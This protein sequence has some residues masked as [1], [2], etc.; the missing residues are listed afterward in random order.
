MLLSVLPLK[1]VSL[2]SFDELISKNSETNDFVTLPEYDFDHLIF[3]FPKNITS[4]AISESYVIM[5]ERLDI[6]HKSMGKTYVECGINIVLTSSFLMVVPIYRPY[7]SSFSRNLYPDPLWYC[8]VI[9]K[10]VLP[11]E[12]PET[13]GEGKKKSPF[14][15]LRYCSKFYLG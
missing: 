12:W 3:F 8:G 11:K 1:G 15:M 14:E 13:V 5:I 10:A 9:N 2:V 7:A 4:R 6:V